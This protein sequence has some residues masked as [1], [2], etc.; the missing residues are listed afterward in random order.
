VFLLLL[1]SHGERA[2]AVRTAL[3]NFSAN[4]LHRVKK[5]GKSKGL[6]AIFIVVAYPCHGPWQLFFVAALRHKIFEFR[7]CQFRPA[8]S[9]GAA[10]Q[11]LSPLALRLHADHPADTEAVGEH[12]KARRPKG[13]RERHPHLSAIG[14]GGK[15]AL[16]FRL[17]G[18]S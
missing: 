15:R 7:R 9:R 10:K 6:V 16:G 18:H 17:V 13:L 4:P 1:I 12:A 3:L 2:A 5:G 8:A 11:A 14:E